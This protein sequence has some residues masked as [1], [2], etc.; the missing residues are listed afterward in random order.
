M[1]IK[2]V[3]KLINNVLVLLNR[4]YILLLFRVK[5]I[6]NMIRYDSLGKTYL[7]TLVNIMK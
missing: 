1:L 4:F 7:N 6:N 2:L 5:L 3:C